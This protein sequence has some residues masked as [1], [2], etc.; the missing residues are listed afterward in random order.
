V[1]KFLKGMCY[2]PFPKG[3]DPSNAN[4]TCIWFGSDI[5]TYNIKPLWGDSFSPVDGPDVGKVFT[6]RN[7]L[8]NLSDLGVN[9]I[10]LYDW[11][12]R[13][14][15]TPFLDYCHSLGIQVLVPVSNYNLGAFGTPPDMDGSI[16]GLMNSFSN[17]GDSTGTDYHP[18][19]YGIT[20]GSETDQQAKIPNGYVAKYTTE[21]V[22]I[23]EQLYSEFREVLIGHPISFAMSGPGWNGDY[24]CFGYLD[25]LLLTLLPCNVR[26]LNK[27]LIIC[28]HTYNEAH[29]LYNNAQ[30]SGQGWVDLAWN[31]YNLPML[32]CEIGCSRMT[33]GDYLEVIKD[34]IETSIAY[35]NTTNNKGKLLGICHFQYCDKVW[36]P[37]T[38][39]GA[40]GIVLNTNQVTDVVHYG[41]KDFTHW[42]G[43]SCNN[44]F[45]NIQILDSNPS[46]DIIKGAYE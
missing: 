18:A 39:E 9:L 30:G 42:V 15:H 17:T 44:N 21:W 25:Q 35:G 2:A 16:R 29:Y 43:F 20:I 24:P 6:G 37:D 22:N 12:S 38:T 7:D 13:N 40:F 3:Y 27:R 41:P 19:I 34:Q 28:P 31:K 46:L 5:A 36:I 14:N 33:R 26:N 32:F 23:E 45:L 8:K 11:D 4:N 10:R 1:S